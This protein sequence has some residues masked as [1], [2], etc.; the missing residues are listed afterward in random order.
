MKLVISYKGKEWYEKFTAAIEIDDKYGE[1][2]Q[3]KFIQIEIARALDMVLHDLS[4]PQLATVMIR[5]N[6]AIAGLKN[7]ILKGMAEAES[8]AEEG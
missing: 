4:H 5:V 8:L 1:M 3:E 2:F 6:G 7:G